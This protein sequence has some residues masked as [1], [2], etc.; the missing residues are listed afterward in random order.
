MRLHVGFGRRKVEEN[1]EPVLALTG[2]TPVLSALHDRAAAPD[3]TWA[4]R[5]AGR[6]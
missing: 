3:E 1:A 2:S 5:M 6:R 4:V